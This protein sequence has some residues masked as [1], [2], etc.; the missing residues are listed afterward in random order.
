MYVYKIINIATWTLTWMISVGYFP[1]PYIIEC[2]KLIHIQEQKEHI[3]LFQ[4]WSRLQVCYGNTRLWTSAS[5]IF[6]PP[7]SHRL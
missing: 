6:Q 2:Y 3:Y 7:F 1:S 5:S 4:F